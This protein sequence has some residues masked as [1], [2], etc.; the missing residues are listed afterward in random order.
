[1]HK[2]HFVLI[3]LVALAGGSIPP[4]AK[5]GLQSF[6]PFTLVFFRFL[7]ASIVLYF[8]VPKKELSIKNLFKF[9]WVGLVGALNPIFIFLALK[10][11][12]SNITALFYAT[13]PGLSVLYLLLI[14]HVRTS[15]A[16]IAG[17]MLGLMGVAMISAHTATAGSGHNLY[18]GLVLAAVAVFAFFAYGIMSKEELRKEHISGA[19]LAFYFTLITV[20]VALPL[21]IVET[22][23]KPWFDSISLSAFMATLYLGFIGTGVQYLL[24]QKAL[25]VMEAAQANI[26]IYLQPIVTVVFAALLVH[27]PVTWQIVL[28]GFIVLLGARL[29]LDKPKQNLRL[30]K[31]AKLSRSSAR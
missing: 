27:E 11:I 6:E 8:F 5:L 4:F 29:A 25:H 2:K 17:F 15:G 10:Y 9:R 3:A 1:M 31:K 16:Q 21:A 14:K 26:F 19:A 12:P 18:L 24:Y 7:F 22:A 20:L 23:R 13:I 28:A 30:S